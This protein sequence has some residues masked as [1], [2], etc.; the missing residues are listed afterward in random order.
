M[1]ALKIVRFVCVAWIFENVERAELALERV[2]DRW[3]DDPDL[4]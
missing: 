3:V 2:L 1:K 4:T